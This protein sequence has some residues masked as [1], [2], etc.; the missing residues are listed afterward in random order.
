MRQ[1]RRQFNHGFEPRLC[2]TAL[3]PVR[4]VV[5]DA[6]NRDGGAVLDLADTVPAAEV[7]P[8][9]ALVEQPPSSLASSL[10]MPSCSTARSR[11]R[12]DD[13]LEDVEQ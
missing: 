9:A 10:D 2:A 4:A 8:L 11:I 12:A 7:G 1:D 5:S 13:S 6:A 3:P